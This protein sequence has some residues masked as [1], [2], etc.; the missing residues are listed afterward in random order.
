MW[1]ADAG[2]GALAGVRVVDFGQYIAGP[3][4]A[5]M[6]A[7]QGAD[8][9]RV[10]PPGGPRWDSPANAALLRGR[11][12]VVL[13]LTLAEDRERALKLMA[14][15]D[16]VIENFRPGVMT[17]LGIGPERLSTVAPQLIYCSMPGFGHDDERADIP[18][19]EG[20]VMA[21]GGAY[22]MR[23]LRIGGV[24]QADASP[25]SPPSPLHPSSAPSRV[26]WRW[27]RH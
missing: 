13:D 22:S 5:M 7:D 4:A 18:G 26:Q 10:D 21:A 9:I 15:A 25:C 2:G 11:R 12:S 14:G 3:M 20:V 6:L 27:W 1:R 17:R 24:T 23:G 8:V 19:W 16:V